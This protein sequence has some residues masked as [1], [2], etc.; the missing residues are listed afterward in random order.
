MVKLDDSIGLELQIY[1]DD[2]QLDRVGD[3]E[4]VLR[5][6]K[7]SKYLLALIRGEFQADVSVSKAK[8]VCSKARLGKRLKA[9]MDEAPGTLVQVATNLGVDT[10]AGESRNQGKDSKQKQRLALIKRRMTK[11]KRLAKRRR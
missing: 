11:F 4:E 7:D 1:I 10:G 3:A 8:V 5:L 9:R 6:G 2:I